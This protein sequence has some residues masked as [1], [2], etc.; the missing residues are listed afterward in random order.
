MSLNQNFVL[1]VLKCTWTM[2]HKMT[3]VKV[4]F[5]DL[6]KNMFDFDIK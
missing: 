1:A 3:L 2:K 4:T 6:N 5:V